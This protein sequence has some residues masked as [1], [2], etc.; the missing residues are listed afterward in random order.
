MVGAVIL[1]ELIVPVVKLLVEVNVAC[2]VFELV[3]ILDIFVPTLVLPYNKLLDAVIVGAIMVVSVLPVIEPES[4]VPVI[5]LIF[6]PNFP[7]LVFTFDSILV[8]FVATLLLVPYI[9]VFA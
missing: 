9:K 1:P 6:E 7:C 4:I 5:M 2:F 3:S 8:I